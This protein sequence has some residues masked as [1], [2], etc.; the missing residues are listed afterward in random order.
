MTESIDFRMLFEASP[1]L[2]LV[3][4]PDLRIAAVSDAYARATMTARDE[5]VGRHV[6]DVFPD[7][8]DDSAAAGVRNL[9]ASLDR[10]VRERI[11]DS[12]PVQRYDIRRPDGTYETRFWSPSNSPVCADDGALRY[13]IHRVEDV[14]E[15][16]RLQSSGAERRRM[17]QEVFARTQEVAEA[18]RRLKEV[19]AELAELY[20]RT[21]ELDELKSQFF[22]TVSHEL[23][24]PLTL[25][26]APVRKLLDAAPAGD[27][28]RADLELI[29]RNA[30]LL[31][32][33][34]NNLLAASRLEAGAVQPNYA[35]VDAAEQVRLATA[36]F[37]SLAV[38]RG[39]ELVVRTAP[40]RAELDPEHLQQIL[41][42]LLSNAFKFTAAGGVVRCALRAA[43]NRLVVE[44]ADS[45]PG[46]D[47]AHR[48]LVFDRFR[49]V[50]GGPARAVG[51]T[52]LGLSIVR[53][54][55]ALHR[56]TIEIGDAPEGGALLVV[57]LPTRAPAG[58]PVRADAAI[59]LS[60]ERS[61]EAVAVLT[62]L[63][64]TVPDAPPDTARP[65]SRP[66][67]VVIEDNADLNTLVRQALSARYEVAAALDGFAGL[68]L[69]RARKPDLIVCDIMMPRLSGDD[70]LIRVRADPILATTPVLILSARA[71]DATRLALL[72]AGAN[73]YLAKPFGLDELQAR[74]DNLVNL[75]LTEE[76]LRALGIAGE[77][78]RIAL[79][80]HRTVTRRLF[81]I[82]LQLSG[83]RSMARVPVV[84]Q[85]IDAAVAE[86]D[87]VIGEIHHTVNE[88]DPPAADRVAFRAGLL[89]L[90][91]Q[92]AE[93]LRARSEVSFAGAVDALDRELTDPVHDAVR[94]LIA[95][96]AG[97]ATATA[98]SLHATVSAA[99]LVVTVAE[100]TRASAASA[101]AGVDRLLPGS[102]TALGATL[103]VATPA[104]DTTTWTWTVPISSARR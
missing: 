71:D 86:L 97:R 74:V 84:G 42:N 66:L 82:G 51:G 94:E 5:I 6:F 46:I 36:F 79:E 50:D 35:R 8:P 52:G 30:R 101:R 10:V 3:L 40:V 18:S 67:V 102:L 23:R 1:A 14:T 28:V 16:V 70:L 22:A 54:L 75:R 81:A 92:C 11:A 45:G 24:T 56:G 103:A 49:Q 59:R 25:I 27:P 99:D 12:M 31:L 98:L 37:E 72:R 17:E 38:D 100:T 58:T 39:V 29:A 90:F 69:A 73:D 55:V 57:D 68:E 78:E 32:R 7:N 20:A 89:D 63:A 61:A 60:D 65:R 44:I 95:D 64:P 88:L 19:N 83:I 47:A 53:D 96:I 33:Q 34:V 80:L 77:R 4:R 93:H 2:Y 48:A 41:V 26:L 104:P 91:G 9:R 43:A 13:I 85:R 15:F 87:S 62:D 76:R 21:K